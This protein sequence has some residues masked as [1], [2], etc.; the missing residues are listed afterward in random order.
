MAV[1][2]LALAILAASLLPPPALAKR[3]NFAGLRQCER[4]AAAQ[5]RR[6][7]PDFRRFMI[8]RSS[9]HEEKFADQVGTQFVSAVYYGKAVLDG[10]AGP[11]PVRFICLHGG[12]K[13]APVFVYT[14]PE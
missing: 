9:V 11:K 3:N 8:D 14:M 10:A 5:L 1:R 13:R 2:T 7:N 4:Q 12:Y 6:Q